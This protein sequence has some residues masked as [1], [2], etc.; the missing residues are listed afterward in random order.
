MSSKVILVTGASRGCGRLIVEQALAR[1]HSVVATARDPRGL[2][3]R[4][5]D[6]PTV[7]SVALD[8]TDEAQAHAAAMAAM[9]C[10]GRI[11][12]LINNAGYGLVGA[13]EEASGKEIEAIYRTNVFGM[14][15]VTRA[16]L[17]YMRRRRTG[18]VINF[19]A[20]GGYVSHA[21]WG[22]YCSTKFAV[23][24]LTEA[25]VQELQP[26]GIH[27]TAVAPG[28]FRTDFLDPKSL[29]ISSRNLEDYRATAGVMRQ[30]SAVANRTQSGD[31]AKL[32]TVLMNLIDMP[33][34]PTR[35]A[36]GR[37]AIAA[38]QAK[39]AATAALLD[40]WRDLS[41]STDFSSN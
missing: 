13:V 1:G 31:P 8:V 6:H 39:N 20:V 15:A 33:N 16:V 7:L 23:E 11:D 10:F 22:V 41:A 12:V 37:D 38:I 21:G 36:L 17:P 4:Y 32:A 28:H 18:H 2:V 5:R 34:P 26:V 40:Q 27:V 14:L 30:L 25:L 3:E 19:S 9:E 35:L 24:A 29:S